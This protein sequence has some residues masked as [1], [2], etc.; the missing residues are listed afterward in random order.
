[1]HRTP[2][3]SQAQSLISRQPVLATM[4]MPH[5]DQAPSDALIATAPEGS[6]PVAHVEFEPV[7][8]A[9]RDRPYW[10]ARVVA[11]AGEFVDLRRGRQQGWLSAAELQAAREAVAGPFLSAYR[12]QWL[13]LNYMPRL[14]P[15]R[16]KLPAGDLVG[17]LPP[18]SLTIEREELIP[19]WWPW[20]TVG[21][22]FVGTTPDFSAWKWSGSGVL[23]G[24]NLMLTAS[25]V[26]P[27]DADF[28]WMRFIPDYRDGSGPFGDS[29]VSQFR[30]HRSDAGDEYDYVICHLYTPLGER[31]GWMGSW[32]SSDDSFYRNTSWSSIGYPGDF[33]G[34]ERPV[35]EW[36]VQPDDTNINGGA[37]IEFE[38]PFATHG[39]SGGPA[40]GWVDDQPR[41][42]GVCRGEEKTEFLWWTTDDDTIF[43][44]G[45]HMVDLI[46]YGLTNWPSS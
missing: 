17:V 26:A 5:W 34:G 29:F 8:I 16:I 32:A 18:G 35:V 42:I 14:I 3:M 4:P 28:W 27:W 22:V 46:K 43:S 12:P 44:G 20:C 2:R 19:S 7:A 23:V 24:P 13:D 6:R 25:H 40:F 41:V 37:K 15:H 39:W 30:G 21:R 38:P 11:D 36:W 1:M 10:R 9:G 33:M 45:F 31:A